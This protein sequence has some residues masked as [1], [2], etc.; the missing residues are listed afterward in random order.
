MYGR[1]G[2]GRNPSGSVTAPKQLILASGSPRRRQ[3]LETI[4]LSFEVLPADI[5]E[6]EHVGESAVAY[7]ERVAAEKAAAVAHRLTV[8]GSSRF[9][10]LAADTTVDL[11]GS[12]LAKPADAADATRM[13]RTPLRAH[14]SG[15]YRRGG[16]Y[17]VGD[18]YRHGHDRCDVCPAQ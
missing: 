11:D 8:A 17:L 18:P 3:L 16:A 2:L 13:L 5:D 12:I 1:A 7:V 15:S 9:V 4:G 14:P 6:T 10:V